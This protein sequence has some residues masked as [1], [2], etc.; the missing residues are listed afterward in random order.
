[1]R[2]LYLRIY[3]AV[4]LSLAVFALVAALAW[5]SFA[6]PWS[7][8]ETLATVARNLLPPAAAPASEQQAAL[9]RLARDLHI[10]L[11]LFA[12]DGTRTALVGHPIDSPQRVGRQRG[13]RGAPVWAARLEDGRWLA[14][15]AP[16]RGG[17][18]GE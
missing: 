18:T 14:A 17:M 5:H 6:E 9:Q 1:M 2:R 8:D 13:L 7:S 4:V 11:A 12:P 10:D 3:L 16:Y 15:R